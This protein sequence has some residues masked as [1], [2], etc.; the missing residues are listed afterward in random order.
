MKETPLVSIICTA[1]NHESYIKDALEGFVMQKT[2][3]PFEIIVSDDASSDM[4]A[5]IID[6]YEKQY[7]E[8]FN[9][10][11]HKENQYSKGIPFFYN[12]LIPNAQ[13]KYIAICEG[14]DYWTDPYKLQKQV[15]FLEANE[16]YVLCFHNAFLLRMDTVKM[17]LFRKFSKNI[18]RTKDV[19]MDKWF[20]PSASIVLRSEVIK[21]SFFGTKKDKI[22]N[23]DMLLIFN[24]SLHGKLYYINEIMSV[25]R[26]NVPGSLTETQ[27]SLY[28]KYKNYLRYLLFI[29]RKTNNKF[30]LYIT[31]KVLY[32]FMAAIKN[33]LKK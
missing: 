22:V 13:G 1:Y 30:V 4:T 20:C 14:D 28:L 29:N 31:I 2:N 23:G 11:F 8:L 9:T 25:Y 6:Q 16:D 17:E 27:N 26:C 18:Y 24:S 12:E 3:F 19:I 21:T 5:S 10:F 33:T 15:D 7:P 32:I